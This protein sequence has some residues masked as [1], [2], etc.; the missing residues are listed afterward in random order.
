MDL[1]SQKPFLGCE[2]CDAYHCCD[3]VSSALLKKYFIKI[4]L[5]TFALCDKRSMN[6][7]DWNVVVKILGIGLV[8]QVPHEVSN[9]YQIFYFKVCV[10]LLNLEYIVCVKVSENHLSRV[11]QRIVSGSNVEAA[12][13]REMVRRFLLGL[14]LVQYLISLSLG[15]EYSKGFH[16][17]YFYSF[18]RAFYLKF[19][20]FFLNCF[21]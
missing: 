16:D 3:N 5:V 17:L 13:Y 18:Y 6:W 10:T 7:P 21:L 9:I 19:L 8:S 4:F 1:S 14:L 15:L 12:I 20:F 2:S 11:E